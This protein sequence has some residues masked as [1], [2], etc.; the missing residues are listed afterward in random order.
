[1][2]EVTAR[3]KTALADRYRIE[4]ELGAGGMATVYLAHDV[5]HDRPVALKVL[6]PEL[7]AIV[8]AERF[9]AEIKTTAN[10][11]HPNILSLFD[12]GE[13]GGVVYYVMPYVQGENLRDRIKR[14]HQLPVDDALRITREVLDALEHAH[15][16][17]VIHRDIK[18]ENILF[19]GGHAMVADFGIALA[20]S[21]SDGG[22]RMTETGLSLGTPHYMA[23]EQAMGEREITPRADVYAVGCVLYEMLT[24]EPPFT[25]S[26]AQAVIARVMTE[27]PRSLTMQRRTVPP[28]VEAAVEKA[29]SKVPAD[30]F[31]S[32]AQFAEALAH[33]EAV[34]LPAPSS[35]R[36]RPR[37]VRWREPV[38]LIPWGLAVA[39]LAAAV[40]VGRPRKV[41]PVP[42]VRFV[43]AAP[44]SVKPFDGPPW[45]ATISPNGD[46][47]VYQVQGS[48]NKRALYLLRTDEL[49]VH[50]IPGTAE[51]Y[52]PFFSP[53][54]KWI[55][56]EVAGKE[57][58]V[59]LDGSAPVTITDAGSGNGVEWTA[60]NELI[61]G[62]SG[63]F[64][65]LS[66]VSA[67]GGQLA[68]LTQ[69][70]TSRGEREHLWP[71][72]S[73]DGKTI[74]FVTWM[75]SLAGS[76]LAITSIDDGKVVPLGLPGIRPLAILDDMLLYVQADGTVMAVRLDLRGK[77][78]AG[79]PIP[80]H[81]PVQVQ[82]WA[83]GNSGIFIS[84]GGALVA[85]RGGTRGRLT[86]VSRDGRREPA[87]ESA[88]EFE[89]PRLSPDER[90]ISVVVKD[91]QS[92]DVWIY[93]RTLGTFSRLTSA[94]TVTAAEWNST[95]SAIVFTAAS[96]VR[97]VVWSQGAGGG[98][99]PRK[100]FESPIMVSWATLSPDG[101]W[102]LAQSFQN[103]WNILRIR[104]DSAPIAA[105]YLTSSANELAPTFSPDGKWVAIVS[106]ESGRSEVYVRSFP[107]PSSRIQISVS[108]GEEPSWSRDGTRLYYREGAALLVARVSLAPTFTLLG[109]DT[110]LA[111]MQAD[112]ARVA[113][114][115]VSG[116]G[117][118]ILAIASDADDFQLVVSPNWITEL[119]RRVAEADQG[120]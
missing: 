3:L 79:R 62:A 29:L 77:K 97:S 100:V 70:D 93:D 34:S 5:R 37:R 65:G 35:Q 92:T 54:G 113:N 118:R 55:G 88:R 87:F 91:G 51:G 8:G 6:R 4:R 81:D 69:P 114:Y 56:F 115:D 18:P 108:G 105:P 48:S 44:D 112:L 43:L 58:K 67:A 85:S 27:E 74:V 39:A 94:A 41:V 46:A 109:R 64:S 57:R 12:S 23:P 68:A 80:V 73:A 21:R 10:L 90:K 45:P 96:D 75:G 47:V 31:S 111:N 99:P 104:L 110:V 11:Q 42:T 78:I 103:T 1:M 84:R 72:A 15:Q 98:S 50:W 83:N 59:R 7:A 33:P 14:E 76:R 89:Y 52:Q 28:H 38:V 9:L 71:I 2:T 40:I 117:K 26:T 60:Q 13:A 49:E 20:V 19:Y 24:G 82:G 95:G 102:L 16:H 36:A 25:G 86:W 101:Q 22:T 116:D 66:R 107:D 61:F 53:D 17:R 119:R 63:A 120:R 30:R 106:D 32:A